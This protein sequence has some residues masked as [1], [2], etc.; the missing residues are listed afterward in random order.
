LQRPRLAAEQDRERLGPDRRPAEAPLRP[1]PEP[2]RDGQGLRSPRAPDA[3][4]GHPGPQR[5]PQRPGP[6]RPGRGREPDQRG[7]QVGVRPRQG[8]RGPEGQPELPQ[9][10][11]G[12]VRHRGPHRLRAAVLQRLRLPLQHEEPELPG[13]PRGQP[14]PVHRAGVLRSRRRRPRPRGRRLRPGPGAAHPAR[15]L[16]RARTPRRTTAR[17]YDQ[18]AQNKR[19]S[20]LLIGG[21][22]LLVVAVGA[23]V[24]LLVGGGPVITLV[25]LLI[26]GA[27]AAVSYWKSDAIALRVS[28]ARPAP[29]E[30]YPRYHNLVEGL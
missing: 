23:A 27:S 21:F 10:A 2:G 12:A 26:A 6:A 24:N 13:Q 15:G 8:L 1:D 4:G 16:T 5:G 14:V 11:G 25:A 19:R 29:E 7:A 22:V 17:V 28:R 18:I 3:R 20:T 9:P 30:Q